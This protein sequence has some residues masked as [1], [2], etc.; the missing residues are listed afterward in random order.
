MDLDQSIRG[1]HFQ[2]HTSVAMT[3]KTQVKNRAP[4]PIQITAEQLLREAKERGLEDTKKAPK[5]YI[6]DREE[7]QMYQTTK[8]KDFEDQIRRQR[9]HIGTWCRYALWEASQKEFERARSV[10][11]RALDVDYRNHTTWMKYAEMEMQNQFINHARNIWDRAVTLLPRVDAFWYKYTYMEELIGAIDQAR[12]L[13][14]RW[15]KWE[16]DDNAWSAYIRFELR[17]GNIERARGLYDRYVSQLPTA[18]AY[19]RYARWEEKLGNRA[20]AR[21][22]YERS[23]VELHIQERT[24]S[25]LMNFARFEERCKEIER[26]RVIFQYALDQ[27]KSEGSDERVAELNQEFIAFEKRH[28][29][30][31]DIE[32]AVLSRRRKQYESQ[33]AS[34]KYNYDVWFDYARLEEENGDFEKARDVYERAVACLPPLAEKRYWRRYIY[35]WICYALFEELIAKDIE[36]TR[37][38]YRACLALI[39]HKKFTFGKIWL[40]AAKLEVRAKDLSAARLILGRAIGT[41]GKKNIF[42]GY[43][44][45]ELQLGEVDRCR[46]IYAKYIEYAPYNAAVWIAFAKLEEKVGE[47]ARVRALFELAVSQPV[48]DMP[49]MLWKSYIDFELAEN[50]PDNARNLYERLLQ[51]TSHVKVW[52]SFGQFEALQS[53]IIQARQVFQRGYDALKEQ[54]LKEER[55]MLLESWREAESEAEDG[56]KA[57]VDAKFPRKLKMRRLVPAED[58]EN[59]WEDYYDYVFPDDAKPIKGLKLLENAAKWKQAMQSMQSIETHYFLL[60]YFRSI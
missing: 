26:A 20:N 47:S 50:M 44:A 13:F 31:Q 24:E 6:A 60:I 36:R 28:G 21:E 14:E 30:R 29:S 1:E 8:R 12:Q 39:P 16:P 40:L 58:G 54:E 38:V 23:L 35:L 56:D 57:S 4:A 25:L 10:F 41:C 15:M 55:V 19:L 52:I 43:V 59:Q 27:A 34:D 46:T 53:G 37:E 7:L 3:S 22:V 32:E 33:I 42:E 51:R 17:Q 5:L 48:L 45:L 49:E 2:S 18:R 11:E 9:H